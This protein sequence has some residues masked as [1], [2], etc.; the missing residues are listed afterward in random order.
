MRRRAQR[1]TSARFG[2]KPACCASKPRCARCP[3]RMLAEGT[4]PPGY[5]V[6]QRR[7]VKT[8]DAERTR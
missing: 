1:R 2:P 4:L 3:I 6:R 5:T 7:L 8:T